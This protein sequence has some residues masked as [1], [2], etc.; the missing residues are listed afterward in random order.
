MKKNLLTLVFLSGFLSW[1]AN[2]QSVGV[3]PNGDF[4][5]W[6]LTPFK[7]PANFKMSNI[8]ES[9]FRTGELNVSQVPSL[10]QGA[11]ALQ[12]KTIGSSK[13]TVAGMLSNASEVN[14]P[15]PDSWRGGIPCSE[16]PTGISGYYTYYTSGNSDSAI[17]A[18]Q[19]RKN[20]ANIG[21]YIFYLGGNHTVPVPFN[22][23]FSPALSQTP[24]SMLIILVSSDLL[25]S[26]HRIPGS[27]L[28][29]DNI[30]LTGV[31]EQPTLLNG[32]FEEWE[33][34]S[35]RPILNSW[36]S[37]LENISRTTDAK[38]GMY[39]VQ[40]TTLSYM[41]DGHFRLSPAYVS[42][43][44]WNKFTQIWEGGFPCEIQKDTLVFWYK[45]SPA[46]P[47]DHA[48]IGI[49]FKKNSS[50][51]GGN[52]MQ[53]NA[54]SEYTYKELPI[55]LG[56]QI[57]DTAVIN[58]SSSEWLSDIWADTAESYVGAVLKIDGLALKSN[59]GTIVYKE[60]SDRSILFYPNPMKETGVF[61]L[62]PEL[63][64]V[65]MQIAI[66][67]V[68][69]KMVRNISVSSAK[70]YIN[71]NEFTSGVYFYK[72]IQNSNILK[73]GKIIVE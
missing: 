57:S 55:N 4:E 64:L 27:T 10:T 47:N 33:E 38:S 18:V 40:M 45:Y 46:N 37:N 35:T 56:D 50:F 63:N 16:A 43:G 49:T 62:S 7:L 52:G 17:F 44:E 31:N 3:I 11:Y 6:Q 73:T 66:Y 70:V 5:E 59:L 22:F 41:E 42:N 25:H 20:S 29:I 28:T 15:D 60:K 32:D 14:G 65:G 39:A 19:F 69:G 48:T 26:E 12:L 23:S 1:L 30:S 2:A 54:A 67:N 9:I 51:I 36:F 61:E 24:D 21:T 72:L 71:K 68:T 13:D 34:Y 58:I 53:L 8:E